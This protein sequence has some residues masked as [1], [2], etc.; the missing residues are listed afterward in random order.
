MTEKAGSVL[1]EL[2]PPADW[3]FTYE[4]MRIHYFRALD[5]YIKSIPESERKLSSGIL[6]DKN[7]PDEALAKASDYEF[8]ITVLPGL[9]DPD[10]EIFPQGTFPFENLDRNEIEFLAK[11]L[12]ETRPERAEYFS[13]V[14]EPSKPE[15]YQPSFDDL[16]KPDQPQ[17]H[18]P[19]SQILLKVFASKLRE[20]RI[21]NRE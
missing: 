8:A 11:Y 7:S 20:G 19:R 13:K 5:T 6:D 9:L 4:D 15:N 12:K 16:K 14:L 2:K 10:P 17:P 1:T 21:L 18:V 3:K